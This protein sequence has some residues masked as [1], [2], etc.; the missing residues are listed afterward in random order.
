MNIHDD[1]YQAPR[2]NHLRTAL[3]TG[4]CLAIA[5]P[6]TLLLA[7]LGGSAVLLTLAAACL[8]VAAVIA[9]LLAGGCVVRRRRSP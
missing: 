6:L 7:E 1:I 4:A 2:P 5:G 3:V 9:V 8:G